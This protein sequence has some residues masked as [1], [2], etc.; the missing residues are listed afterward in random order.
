MFLLLMLSFS[1][2]LSFIQNANNDNN[3]IIIIQYKLKKLHSLSLFRSFEYSKQNDL[4][5]IRIK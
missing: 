5:E 3:K 2:S 4:E 1:Y